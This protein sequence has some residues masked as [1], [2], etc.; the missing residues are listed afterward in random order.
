M[1]TM[2]VIRATASLIAYSLFPR[3]GTPYSRPPA[4]GGSTTIV[5]KEEHHWLLHYLQSGHHQVNLHFPDV[6][7]VAAPFLLFRL[8][9]LGFS[10]CRVIASTRGL[11][12]TADR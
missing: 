10:N 12:L 7:L 8:K 3:S 1:V 9:R 2:R 11:T 5:P 6:S 4:I